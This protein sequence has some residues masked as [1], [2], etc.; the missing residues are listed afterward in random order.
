ML[1]GQRRQMRQQVTGVILRLVQGC[2]RSFEVSSVPQDDLTGEDRASIANIVRSADL[3]ADRITASDPPD[4]DSGRAL[5]GV[6]ELGERERPVHSIPA[7]SRRAGAVESGRRG[8]VRFYNIVL[9]NSVTIYPDLTLDIG[10]SVLRFEGSRS[11]KC[12]NT[13]LPQSPL[14]L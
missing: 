14:L 4:T 9:T 13:F 12:L 11:R 8:A 10:I 2:H 1:P 7:P 6:G 5:Q 3:L